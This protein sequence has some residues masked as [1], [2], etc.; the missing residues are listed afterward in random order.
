M[1]E[2]L[3]RNLGA[4]ANLTLVTADILKANLDDL[5]GVPGPPWAVAGNLPYHVTT[6]VLFAM[7]EHRRRISRMVFT[8]QREVAERMIAKPGS[9]DYSALS[10]ALAHAGK[11]ELLFR[12][13]AG[14]FHPKPK[15]D[16]AVVR[17]TPSAES[18]APAH[19]RALR[20]V[21]RAAFGQRRKTLLNALTA[22]AGGRDHAAAAIAKAG[23]DGNARGETLTLAE[24]R[25]LA[26][27]LLRA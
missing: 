9:D 24:F 6:P 3:I 22:I 27:Q 4:P 18:F 11:T 20:D 26:E 19:D 14:A 5:L 23:L 17:I 10:V 16:S 1:A 13:G 21:V 7:Q 2:L 15:V 12:I 8:V 25:A